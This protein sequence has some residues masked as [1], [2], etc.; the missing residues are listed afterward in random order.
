MVHSLPG[1]LNVFRTERERQRERSVKES[2]HVAK[3]NN[4]N[5]RH[6]NYVDRCGEI[7]GKCI[8]PP[9][10]SNDLSNLFPVF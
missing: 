4:K 6:Y 3:E 8:S 1:R 2:G 7:K 9:E 10:K 5:E